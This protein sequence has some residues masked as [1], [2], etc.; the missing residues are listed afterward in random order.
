MKNHQNDQIVHHIEKRKYSDGAHTQ[1]QMKARNTQEK[2][3]TAQMLSAK[4]TS[5]FH[6]LHKNEILQNQNK[7][8]AGINPFSMF[9]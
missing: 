8:R 1:N 2:K 9:T 6:F 7:K 5:R 3:K 4:N